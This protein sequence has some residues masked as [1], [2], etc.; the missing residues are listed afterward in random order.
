MIFTTILVQ[1]DVDS[2]ASPRLAFAQEIAGRFEADLIAI[3]AAQARIFVPS[4]EN[5]QVAAE[6]MKRRRTQIEDRFKTLK[7]EFLSVTGGNGRA[8]WRAELGDPTG[9]VALHARAADLVV[10]GAPAPAAA[11]DSRRTVDAGELDPVGGT[12]RAVCGR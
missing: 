11:G 4:D 12:A 9:T 7:E 6:V 10:T 8:S 5:G 2:P 1:L 3:V